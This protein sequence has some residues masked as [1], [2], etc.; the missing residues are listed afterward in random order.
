MTSA[1]F[2]SAVVCAH[3]HNKT[4]SSNQCFFVH[5]AGRKSNTHEENEKGLFVS[6]HDKTTRHHY[7]FFTQQPSTHNKQQTEQVYLNTK[8]CWI[9]LCVGSVISVLKQKSKFLSM[10]ESLSNNF[11]PFQKKVWRIL[12]PPRQSKL[13]R[14]TKIYFSCSLVFTSSLHPTSSRDMKKITVVVCFTALVSKKIEQ[15]N[16]S[17]LV[18]CGRIN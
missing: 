13:C 15:Y 8:K 10:D 14:T 2:S 6:L 11:S 9:Y 16:C 5:V 12:N 7:N 4:K 3:K 1:V 17:C 18:L